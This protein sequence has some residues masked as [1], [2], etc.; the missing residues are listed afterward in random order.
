MNT[1]RLT[2]RLPPSSL[3]FARKYAKEHGISLT[4]LVLR[5]FERL[6]QADAQDIPKEVADITGIIPGDVSVKSEYYEHVENKHK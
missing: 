3:G 2:V 5:Y 1:A 4:A 6:N